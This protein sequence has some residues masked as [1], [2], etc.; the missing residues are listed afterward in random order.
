MAKRRYSDEERAA[1]LAALA[2]NAGNVKKTAD[3]CGVPEPTLR[4]WSRGT[5]HPEALQMRDGK[6]PDLAAL[7]ERFALKCLGIA[8]RKA[9]QMGARDAMVCAGIAVD[10]AALLRG[11]APEQPPEE[12]VRV[13]TVT[14]YEDARALLPLVA[15]ADAVPAGA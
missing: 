1:C 11:V 9:E 7:F 5:R 13:V 2:A 6:K 10:K 14:T 15:P 12:A 3:Q 8:D 4:C